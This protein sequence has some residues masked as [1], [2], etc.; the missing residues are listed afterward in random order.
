MSKHSPITQKF[1]EAILGKET[2]VKIGEFYFVKQ[3]EGIGILNQELYDARKEAEKTK[4]W[5][6]FQKKADVSRAT[7]KTWTPRRITPADIPEWLR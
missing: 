7:I 6:G 2:E 1:K 3:K 4:D 5:H